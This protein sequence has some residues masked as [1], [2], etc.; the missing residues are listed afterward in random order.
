[1]LEDNGGDALTMTADGT[2]TFATP[3]T[4]GGPYAV[5]VSTQPAGQICTVVNGGGNIATSDITNVTVTCRKL[6]VVINE[7][8]ARPATGALGDTNGDNVRDGTGDEFVEIMNNETFAVDVSGWVLKTGTGT[9]AVRYTWLAGVSS[10]AGAR[11]VVFGGGIP[12]GGF[13]G[14]QTF[15]TVSGLSLTDAPTSLTVSLE[16]SGVVLDS[17]TYGAATFGSSCTTACASQVRNPEGTGTFVA[18]TIASGNAGV[19]WSPGVPATG[20]IPKVNPPL[21]VPAPGATQRERA[22]DH[23]AAVQ[24]VHEH[25]HVRQRAP[26][27]VREPVQRHRQRGHV[28]HVDRRGARRVDGAAGAVGAA[29]LRDHVLRAGRRDRHARRSTCRSARRSTWEFTDARGGERARQHHRAER[30][31][32]LPHVLDQRRHRVRRRGRQRRVRRALQPDGGDGR[33]LGLV[34]AA[35]LGGRHRDLRRDA[36]RQHDDHARA[37]LP[38]RRRGLHREPLRRHAGRRSRSRPAA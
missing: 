14:A 32:R 23:H 6:S 15:T 4:L 27:A 37:L 21:S 9:P 3:V 28:V 5:T 13:G 24:H 11:G 22:R 12:T 34:R 38:R 17:Y 33:R 30:D 19:L 25:G 29:E 31:R 16:S 2:F 7:V 26:Q 8:Y 18:H 20:A 10:P 1:M 35:P 36:A